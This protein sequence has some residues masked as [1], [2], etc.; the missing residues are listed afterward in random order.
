MLDQFLVNVRT[1]GGDELPDRC[2][3]ESQPDLTL[4]DEDYH[5]ATQSCGGQTRFAMPYEK[6]D[7]TMGVV[8]GCASCDLGIRWPRVAVV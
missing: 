5:Y 4:P 6:E 7:G 1:Q 2:A 3:G 8:T